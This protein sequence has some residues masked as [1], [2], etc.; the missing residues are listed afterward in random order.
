VQYSEILSPE[1]EQEFIDVPTVEEL[2]QTHERD[3]GQHEKGIRNHCKDQ[4]E[5]NQH[6][7]NTS[8]H[9]NSA[10]NIC[11]ASLNSSSKNGLSF[12][13][14]LCLLFNKIRDKGRTDSAKKGRRVVG[15]G[16]G[17]GAGGRNDPNNVCACE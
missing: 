10:R 9:G 5:M 17:C 15:Y 2:I 12:L 14:C 11:I 1:N 7:C 16:G 6:G 13:F 8:V 4:L 3:S